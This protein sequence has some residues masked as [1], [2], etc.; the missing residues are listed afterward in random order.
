MSPEP[1]AAAVTIM[2]SGSRL[3]S[4]WP[5]ARHAAA[6]IDAAVVSVPCLE[7]FA[8]QDAATRAAVLS[9]GPRIAVE[10]A[11]RQPWDSFFATATLLS[12]WTDLAPGRR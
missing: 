5:H 12:A 2:A 4:H 10:A 11:I 8:E 1:V 9:D 3:A 6:G 7:L